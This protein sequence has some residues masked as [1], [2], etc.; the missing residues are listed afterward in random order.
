MPLPLEST[1]VGR[2][3]EMAPLHRALMQLGQGRGGLVWVEGEPG[4]GK[5]ALVAAVLARS[6]DAG[7]RVFSASGDPLAQPFG[8][9]L[10]AVCLGVSAQAGDRYRREIAELLEGRRVGL[11]AVSAALGRMAALVLRECGR[12]SVALVLDDLQW[13]DDASLALWHRLAVTIDE[14]PLLLIGISRPVPRRPELARLRET[15]GSRSDSV[16][17]QLGG[18]DDPAVTTMAT[19]LLREP[20]GPQLTTVLGE[21]A[22]N[23]RY[24]RE[25]LG[26]L[27]GEGQIHHDGGVAELATALGSRLPSL[28][29]AMGRRLG[30]LADPTRTVL[31]AAAILGVRFSLDDLALVSGQ[32]VPGLSRVL[33]EAVDAGVLVSH[34]AE[35]AFRHA[36][37]RHALAAEMPPALAAE[38]HRHAARTLAE[39]PAHWDRVAQHLLASGLRLDE[40][41]VE[42]LARLP[43][44]TLYAL[45]AIA[46][47][48]LERARAATIPGDPRRDLFS[49]RLTTVLRLLHRYDELL[50]VG[51]T[52]LRTVSDPAQLGE[53]VW[54]VA[55]S[56]NQAARHAE[57]D[58]LLT[59]ALS[60]GSIPAPWR[61]RLRA[62]HGLAL[63][64]RNRL[65][66]A[67]EQCQLAVVEGERDG[68][69]NSVGWA[70]LSL[71]FATADRQE[72]RALLERGLREVVGEDP[73][74]MDL[75]LLLHCHYAVTLGQ[76]HQE[77]GFASSLSVALTLAESAGPTRVEQV[78]LFFAEYFFARGDWDSAIL[79]LDQATS[80]TGEY[81]LRK[82]G[83][84]ALIAV[85]RDQLDKARQHLAA[86]AH[87]PYRSGA[88]RGHGAR[89]L[90]A[91]ALLDEIDGRLPDAVSCLAEW[92]D[93]QY[94]PRSSF[95]RPPVLRQLVRLALAAGDGDTA[96]AAV[97]AAR[98]DADP[99]AGPECRRELTICEA[100]VADDCGELLASADHAE[101]NRELPDAAFLLQ[102][103]SVRLAR[104]GD[105]SAA[106]SAFNRAA[107]IY[108][109]LDAAAANRR[110]Q[111]ILRPYGIRRGPRSVQRRPATGWAALTAA[112]QS[113]VELIRQGD[114]NPE[115]AT[116]LV[117]SRR[118]VETHVS[119]ILAKL[120]VRSRTEIAHL[121]AEQLG[122][123]QN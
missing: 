44:R 10:M 71:A 117:L 84:T 34:G 86:V 19:L 46:V 45:P 49:T 81:A 68:D 118:T 99:D 3:R 122:T 98:R 55:R 57:E 26:A 101:R 111:A 70:L 75:R 24:L 43:A 90:E 35:L 107:V 78:N 25:L 61:S 28:D 92:L 14:I 9:R 95:G 15:V 97:D 114:T 27:A 79:H 47:N 87:M 103:A 13:A 108:D 20:P 7:V 123:R 37:I 60:E 22:G 56:Y 53:I 69:P 109:D 4:I 41:A 106:R 32:S 51:A 113:V 11:D 33:S 104:R 121:A 94:E 39:L 8:L 36:L 12:S 38:L 88:G 58:A 48:V 65:P 76:L 105:D 62:I 77:A 119:H 63:V 82:H 29:E 100:L 59:R 23:P 30:F 64:F 31:R 96:A 18:L 17:I 73:D 50:T 52:A 110:L 91:E 83:L 5:T 67:R 102:E 112:E 85:H 80:L 93:P 16:M 40:W 115:I 2:D 42:W 120:Q 74:S 116:R 1:L 66:Q 89:L 54:N 21:A 72:G 6:G